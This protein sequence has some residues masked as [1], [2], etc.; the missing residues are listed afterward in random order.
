MKLIK[1]EWAKCILPYKNIVKNIYIGKCVYGRDIRGGAAHAHNHIDDLH[2]GCLCFPSKKRMHLKSTALHEV[3]HLMAPNSS[4]KVIDTHGKEWISKLEKI[5]GYDIMFY[6]ILRIIKSY[7]TR[8][9]YQF[10]YGIK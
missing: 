7:D 8:Q 2:F 9:Y 1:K 5:A 4:K 3:A 6:E 10:K